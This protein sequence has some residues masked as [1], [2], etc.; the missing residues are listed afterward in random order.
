[1]SVKWVDKANE[2]DK[3][4]KRC[5]CEDKM[6]Q[7]LGR[8]QCML[9][10]IVVISSCDWPAWS[11]TSTSPPTEV[12]VPRLPPQEAESAYSVPAAQSRAGRRSFQRRQYLSKSNRDHL[13]A[14]DSMLPVVIGCDFLRCLPVAVGGR[15]RI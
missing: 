4:T 2:R 13:K 5:A 9:A 8:R 14:R 15:G 10:M 11:S 3:T 12:P 6:E 7:F 1:M